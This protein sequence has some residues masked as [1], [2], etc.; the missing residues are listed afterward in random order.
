MYVERAKSLVEKLKKNEGMNEMKWGEDWVPNWMFY[1]FLLILLHL[2]VTFMVSRFPCSYNSLH[3]LVTLYLTCNK[4]L[5]SSSVWTSFIEIG[6]APKGIN[7][8][9]LWRW[10][11]ESNQ[12]WEVMEKF[13]SLSSTNPYKTYIN[14]SVICKHC[15]YFL[16]IIPIMPFFHPLCLHPRVWK[17]K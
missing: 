5:K 11:G 9:L 10:R 14:A 7:I 17:I 12:L 6:R 13:I 15:E 3:C 8:S 4:C 16:E 2:R 1:S